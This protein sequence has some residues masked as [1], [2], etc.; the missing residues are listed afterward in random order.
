L[1]IFGWN[2]LFLELLYLTHII[3]C[4]T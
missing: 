4:V 3:I 1:V 2:T